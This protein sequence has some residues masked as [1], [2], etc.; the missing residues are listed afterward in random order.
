ML[1]SGCSKIEAY[2]SPGCILF[3]EEKKDKD[4][5]KEHKE[6]NKDDKERKIPMLRVKKKSKHHKIHQPAGMEYSI[7]L[8]G[9]L[10]A[11]KF[12]AHQIR[13]STSFTDTDNS[14]CAHS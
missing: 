1:Y 8:R 12:L 5:R 2:Y 13:K 3:Q 14:F 9:I 7:M 4:G 6:K 10:M 11:M